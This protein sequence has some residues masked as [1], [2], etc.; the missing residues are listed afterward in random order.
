MPDEPQRVYWD[1]NVPLSYLNGVADRVAIIDELFRMARA[2]EIELLTSSISRVEVAFAQSEKQAG[3]LDPQA[4]D[5]IDALWAPGS[6]IK[7]VEFYDLI[8]EKARAL[9]RQGISQGWG[10]L[11]P[12]DAIHLA[13]A[14]QMGVAEFHT[15]CER[16]H[17]WTNELGFA[18]T[19]PQTAQTV[20][21]IE[22][23][24]S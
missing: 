6:P 1:S 12:M 16:L 21:G 22:S 14:Q 2:A 5:A 23:S 9:I 18:V 11:K 8:G 15:Y 3:K 20:L 4:E 24:A 13:T 10:Q 19:E 7:T 17:K